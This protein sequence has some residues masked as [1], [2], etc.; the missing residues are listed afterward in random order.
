LLISQGKLVDKFAGNDFR[1]I[2]AFLG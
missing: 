2:V 1:K